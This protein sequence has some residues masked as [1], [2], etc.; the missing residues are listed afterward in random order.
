MPSENVVG[1]S[2]VFAWAVTPR[3]L[4]VDIAAAELVGWEDDGVSV[5]PRALV[6]V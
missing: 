6:V 5:V 1:V 4:A 2:A 3:D